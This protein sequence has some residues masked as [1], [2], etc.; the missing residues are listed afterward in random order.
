MVFLKQL[1][2]NLEQGSI[3]LMDNWRVH[4][5]KDIRELIESHDCSV[6]Y[7]PTYSPDF[8]PI[9]LIFSKI[10]SFI[11][12]RRPRETSKLLEAFVDS[13]FTVSQ[14]DVL[15]AFRHSGYPL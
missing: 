10:K 5:G 13:L 1:L 3:L 8:N 14:L 7:L 2:A 9:E 11:K 4:H 12:A 6:R 15:N